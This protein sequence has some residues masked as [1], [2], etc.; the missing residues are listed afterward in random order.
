MT[1]AWL[2][3]V[4]VDSQSKQEPEPELAGPFTNRCL[5]FLSCRIPRQRSSMKW[6]AQYR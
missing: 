4:V 6:T 2:R 3:P 1:Q 5:D